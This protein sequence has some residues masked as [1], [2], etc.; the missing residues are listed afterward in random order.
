MTMRT[1]NKFLVLTIA[2]FAV[3]ATAVAYVG[4]HDVIMWLS[5]TAPIEVTTETKEFT[6][7]FVTSEPLTDVVAVATMGLEALFGQQAL[8]LNE[9]EPNHVYTLSYPV[10]VPAGAHRTNYNG[11]ILILSPGV[12]P[13]VRDL[14]GVLSVKI[15]VK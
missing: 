5:G 11:A 8:Y 13:G 12:G 3:T 7:T 10:H 14:V 6:A 1:I 2:F 9:L 4:H 15:E